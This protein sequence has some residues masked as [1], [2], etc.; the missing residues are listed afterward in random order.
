MLSHTKENQPL[1]CRLLIVLGCCRAQLQDRKATAQTVSWAWLCWRLCRKLMVTAC[2]ASALCCS[3]TFQW[4]QNRELGLPLARGLPEKAEHFCWGEWRVEEEQ[5]KQEGHL[6]ASSPEEL[7][8]QWPTEPSEGLNVASPRS[9]L[10]PRRQ[11]QVLCPPASA[12][13]ACAQVG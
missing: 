10:C 12:Q 6:T 1:T 3:F 8:A 2:W 7:I 5:E 11:S 4:E 9:L 13:T